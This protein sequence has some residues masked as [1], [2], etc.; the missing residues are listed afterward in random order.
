MKFFAINMGTEILR[1]YLMMAVVIVAGFSEQWL[2]ALLGLPI[3]LRTILG[4]QFILKEQVSSTKAKVVFMKSK[5]V[6]TRN[7]KVASL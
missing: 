3:F 1:Y 5:N 6:K 7:G 2:L 4:V